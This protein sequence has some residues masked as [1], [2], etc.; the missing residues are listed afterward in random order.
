MAITSLSAH[1]N[2]TFDAAELRID[3][4]IP[5]VLM[6]RTARGTVD[7]AQWDSGIATAFA[8][9]TLDLLSEPEVD[10]RSLH[11][12]LRY[13]G[14]FNSGLWHWRYQ[15]MLSASMRKPLEHVPSRWFIERPLPDAGMMLDLGTVH[16]ANTLLGTV[17]LLGATIRNDDRMLPDSLRGYAPPIRGIATHR[18]TVIIRQHGSVVHKATVPAGPFVIDDLY[19]TGNRGDLNVEVVDTP[20]DVQRFSVLST[21]SPH[22]VRPGT[23]RF[24]LPNRRAA[25]FVSSS[26]QRD[27]LAS[28][29][30]CPSLHL[31]RT[32]MEQLI[33]PIQPACL[34]QPTPSIGRRVLCGDDAYG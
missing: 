28:L 21:T 25:C 11:S 16:P 10:T 4:S 9:Y 5:Q 14:G 26:P 22:M 27:G 12:A 18:S 13:T 23:A 15:G 30:G 17:P 7:P 6:A 29:I 31:P 1:A 8:S 2:A 20:R 32:R 34:T 3:L 24:A 19:P 33:N